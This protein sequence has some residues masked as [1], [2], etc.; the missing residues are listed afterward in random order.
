MLLHPSAL[1]ATEGYEYFRISTF[2]GSYRHWCAKL[3][4]FWSN[5]CFGF[6]KQLAT[7]GNPLIG[8]R[9][10]AVLQIVEVSARARARARARA[11]L[12]NLNCEAA[13]AVQ[14]G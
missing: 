1:K 3:C 2:L 14:A 4:S 5:R 6:V 12:D 8:L 11:H 7:Y 13:G 10:H 9:G